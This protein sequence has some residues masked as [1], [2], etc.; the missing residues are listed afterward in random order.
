[1]DGTGIF[2]VIMI[3][4]AIV[5]II[6]QVDLIDKKTKERKEILEAKMCELPHNEDFI[7]LTGQ[8]YRYAFIIDKVDRKVYYLTPEHTKEIPFDNI[9]SVE[10]LEDNMV[11]FSKKVSVGG[12]ILG[13]VLA[14]GAGMV[15]G[16][17][18]GDTKQ[19]KNVSKVTVKIKI[20]NYSMPS[21]LIDCFNSQELL[22]NKEIWSTHKVYREELQNAQT[23]ADY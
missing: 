10:I 22:G 8:K 1:M 15:V 19:E 23:I 17:L 13:G 3:I 16:G 4:L 7:S 9:I 14:G 6:R 21:I 2:I 11:L 12:A 18:S 5:A 20:R